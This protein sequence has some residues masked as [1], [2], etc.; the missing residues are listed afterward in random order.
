MKGAV[1][2]E[3]IPGSPEAQ[4]PGGECA[5]SVRSMVNS[6]IDEA[7]LLSRSGWGLLD[8]L[9]PLLDPANW[10]KLP[11]SVERVGC[12]SATFGKEQA[13]SKI[14]HSIFQGGEKEEL[15]T[16]SA[17][18]RTSRLHERKRITVFK[19]PNHSLGRGFFLFVHFGVSAFSDD[20]SV[21]H[22]T[23]TSS[24]IYR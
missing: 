6:R 20:S 5:S 24:A 14:Q 7:L 13:V 16:C 4:I 15:S 17:F 19:I 1:A 10:G 21:G 8:E 22:V 18:E 12:S 9:A 3:W 11:G 2:A 23:S